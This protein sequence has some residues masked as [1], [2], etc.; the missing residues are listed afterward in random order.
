[1]IEVKRLKGREAIRLKCYEVK[2]MIIFDPLWRTLKIKGMNKGDLQKLASFSSS[3]VA[4]LA[5]NEKVSL[6]VVERICME[7]QVPIYDVVEI[8]PNDH[9]KQ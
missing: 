2:Q 9:A 6:D 4:K 5:K 8:K 1:M 7:L 3:T